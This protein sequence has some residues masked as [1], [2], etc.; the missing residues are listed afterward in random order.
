[1]RTNMFRGDF[2]GGRHSLDSSSYILKLLTYYGEIKIT[3]RLFWEGEKSKQLPPSENSLTILW[4]KNSTASLW[5][6]AGDVISDQVAD[7]ILILLMCICTKKK[8]I[9]LFWLLAEKRVCAT[10]YSKVLIRD[11]V[12]GKISFVINLI[13][14]F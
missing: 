8:L 7:G 9:M 10:V 3:L 13:T 1:M 5:N 14:S 2:A 12:Q 6:H 11:W 4:R